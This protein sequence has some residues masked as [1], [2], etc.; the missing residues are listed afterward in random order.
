[1]RQ[2]VGLV[3][4]YLEGEKKEERPV[5]LVEV[6]KASW[7]RGGFTEAHGARR[8][9]IDIRHHGMHPGSRAP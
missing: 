6:M 5:K 7:G 9:G 1:M 3:V 2:I 8:G 4:I